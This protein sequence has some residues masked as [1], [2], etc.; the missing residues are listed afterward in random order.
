MLEVLY[1]LHDHAHVGLHFIIVA[2]RT[3]SFLPDRHTRQSLSFFVSVPVH[4]RKQNKHTR[5]RN[6]IG[7][8]SKYN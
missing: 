2:S 4:E 5:Y 6:D 1:T 3:H 8:S 7:D